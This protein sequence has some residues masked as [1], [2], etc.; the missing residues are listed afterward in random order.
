M[1]AG[2]NPDTISIEDATALCWMLVASGRYIPANKWVE[3]LAEKTAA[4]SFDSTID[5]LM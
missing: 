4:E 2:V 5:S 1:L 3:T